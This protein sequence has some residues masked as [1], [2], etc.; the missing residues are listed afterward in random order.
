MNTFKHIFFALFVLFFTITGC[1]KEQVTETQL[2]PNDFELKVSD[3]ILKFKDAEHFFST[4]KQN[5][6][7]SNTER[8]EWEKSQNF[9]SFGRVCDELYFSMNETLFKDDEKVKNFVKQHSDK[10]QLIK[11]SNG[12]LTLET[13]LY[14]NDLRYFA[15]N[16]KMFQIGEIVYLL[17]EEGFASASASKIEKLKQINENNYRLFFNDS[18]VTFSSSLLSDV[19]SVLKDGTYNCGTYAEERVTNDRERT[20]LRISTH[21]INMT[22]NSIESTVGWVS[23]IVRPYKKTL[24]IWYWCTRHI[25]CNIKVATDYYANTDMDGNPSNQWQRLIQ[26][27]SRTNVYASSVSDKLPDVVLSFGYHCTPDIHFGGY[28][29]WGDTPSTNP[30]VVLQCNSFLCP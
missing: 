5:L 18:D 8:F 15:N 17:L 13:I 19:N 24:G 21:A 6:S 12:D 20:Y 4:Y 3:E 22:L 7:F 29:S 26:Q 10:L 16:D 14:S 23:Y 2:T 11:D 30:N 9:S 1:K 25:S 28:N 27:D